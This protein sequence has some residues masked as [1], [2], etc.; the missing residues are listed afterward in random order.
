MK[1][2]RREASKTLDYND[3]RIDS[4]LVFYITYIYIYNRG[5][6]NSIKRYGELFIYTYT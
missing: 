5:E 1:S 6:G 4:I 2:S 3:N